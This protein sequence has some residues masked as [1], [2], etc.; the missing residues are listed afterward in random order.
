MNED[1][2]NQVLFDDQFEALFKKFPKIDAKLIA[3]TLTSTQKEAKKK[4]G[5]I[6][7]EFS[8]N[9]FETIFRLLSQHKIAKEAILDILICIAKGEEVQQAAKKFKLLSESEL[10][11]EIRKLKKQFSKV[12]ENKL[13]GIIISKLRGRAEVQ[14]I[15]KF[16]N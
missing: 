12:P 2:A 5:Q 10:K 11:Q 7:G 14:K 1:L 16:L 8:L 6:F 15:I 9:H 4:A 13:K 3:T